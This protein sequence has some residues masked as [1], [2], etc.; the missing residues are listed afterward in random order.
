MIYNENTKKAINL[1]FEHHANQFDK[2]GYPYILHPIHLAENMDTED[3]TIVA[4]MHDLVED[5]TVTIEDIIDMDFNNNVVEAIRLLTKTKDK[6]YQEYI[7][8]IKKNEI[9]KIVKIADLKHNMDTTRL[10]S[11][12]PE[13]IKRIEKYKHSLEILNR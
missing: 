5:T 4:L 3:T 6:P 7:E 13:T 11:I 10:D 8:D 9:A 1:V 12:D 2:G